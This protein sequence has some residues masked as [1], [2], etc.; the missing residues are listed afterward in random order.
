MKTLMRRMPPI[1]RWCIVIAS[2]IILLTGLHYI[3]PLAMIL[4]PAVA[5]YLI[6]RACHCDSSGQKKS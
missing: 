2:V 6:I 5:G 3:V 4:A 1:L